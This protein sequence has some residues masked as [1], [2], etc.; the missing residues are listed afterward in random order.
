MLCVFACGHMQCPSASAVHLMSSL[1]CLCGPAQVLR[2]V[3]PIHLWT[4]GRAVGTQRPV[5]LQTQ[6]RRCRSMQPMHRR[7]H[8]PRS[9]GLLQL[10]HGLQ[11]QSAHKVGSG[12][13]AVMRS[14]SIG[15]DRLHACHA[16]LMQSNGAGASQACVYQ[17]LTC[18]RTR[19]CASTDTRMHVS[20]EP[21][22]QK[23]HHGI[24]SSIL[25]L[26]H[27]HASW[28]FSVGCA[29]TT[30]HSITFACCLLP[31][32]LNPDHSALL[33]V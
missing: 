6:Q 18:T 32:T 12:M 29:T 25:L 16:E 24:C 21:T 17:A 9:T 22:Q 11:R 27:F 8:R 5:L 33:S 30:S 28:R 20:Q 13:V 1:I 19:A 4:R 15:S 23:G 7:R 2:H 3:L 31:S 26:A 10:P 14:L